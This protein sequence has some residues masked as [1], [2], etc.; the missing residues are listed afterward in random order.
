[1]FAALLTWRFSPASASVFSAESR[2]I[3]ESVALGATGWVSGMR[4]RRSAWRFSI[5]VCRRDRANPTL[6]VV[7][8]RA[9][10]ILEFYAIR[11]WLRD[12][13]SC[14]SRHYSC[15]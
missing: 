5:S 14:L 7:L 4:G 11:P 12:D 1:M 6:M 15:W 9:K 2:L 8:Q 10:A 13:E 3:V